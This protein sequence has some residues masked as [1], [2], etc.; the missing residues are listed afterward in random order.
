[1]GIAIITNVKDISEQEHS[2]GSTL[3]SEV[4]MTGERKRSIT[5]NRRKE[6]RIRNIK[7][8]KRKMYSNKGNEHARY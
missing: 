7:Q 2:A 5:K 3:Q 6:I 1:M 8:R 4:I